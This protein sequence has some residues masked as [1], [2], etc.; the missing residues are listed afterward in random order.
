MTLGN[1]YRQIENSGG[2][3]GNDDIVLDEFKSSPSLPESGTE[4]GFVTSDFV[5]KFV[6]QPVLAA[7]LVTE[8]QV[9]DNAAGSAPEFRS[10]PVQVGDFESNKI[11]FRK[12]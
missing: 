10:S 4:P 11:T 3:R 9:P 8:P 7:Q 1:S 5:P 6:P 2:G 12:R